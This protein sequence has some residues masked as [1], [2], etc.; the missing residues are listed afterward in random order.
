M[1]SWRARSAASAAASTWAFR[2]CS[3][4]AH[5]RMSV[6]VMVSCGAFRAKP[7]SAAT[8]S[9]SRA[10]ANGS[11]TLSAALRTES[12]RITGTRVARKAFSRERH[13]TTVAPSRHAY[14]TVV[15]HLDACIAGSDGKGQRT[16]STLKVT[17]GEPPECHRSRSEPIADERARRGSEKQH[18]GD[19]VHRVHRL[20]LLAQIHARA[21][22]TAV[23][24]DLQQDVAVPFGRPRQHEDRSRDGERRLEAL[25]GECGRL[26]R[27]TCELRPTLGVRRRDLPG[28]AARGCVRGV[29]RRLGEGVAVRGGRGAV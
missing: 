4:W 6:I 22:L 28:D 19:V 23:L 1:L 11:R 12:K 8:C 3:A 29:A 20:A 24:V 17:P 25:R 2:A 27:I 5:A 16:A 9:S 10:S 14:T 7:L 26:V 13:P 18:V 15:V 21:G